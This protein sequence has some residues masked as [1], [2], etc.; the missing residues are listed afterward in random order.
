MNTTEQS[1]I[2]CLK[3]QEH[4]LTDGYMVGLYNGMLLALSFITGDKFEPLNN[5]FKKDD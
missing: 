3:I 1:L 4:C 2:A 5:E